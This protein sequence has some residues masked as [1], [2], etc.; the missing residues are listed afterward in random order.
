MNKISSVSC[1][2]ET[3]TR[4]NWVTFMFKTKCAYQCF[5]K[6]SHIDTCTAAFREFEAQ[7]FEFGE[8]G[9]GG[10]HAHFDANVPKQYSVMVAEIMLKS[11]SS[12]RMFE[13]HP[14]FRKKIPT[15]LVLVWIRASSVNRFAESGRIAGV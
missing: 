12:K 9:F 5:R 4:D 14:G 3:D 8:F 6:Q 11:R 15:R 1:K 7:G 2:K 10:N 13:Q